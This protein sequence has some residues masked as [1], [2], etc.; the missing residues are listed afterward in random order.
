[1][2]QP[3]PDDATLAAVMNP[4]KLMPLLAGQLALAVMAREDGEHET[5]DRLLR[6]LQQI[7]AGSIRAM[8]GTVES[9]R[10]IFTSLGDQ[11]GLSEANR[12][13]WVAMMLGPEEYPFPPLSPDQTFR[14]LNGQA[15]W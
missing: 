2:T 15:L 14:L 3:R 11:M 1:M 12:E 6:C 8:D 7:A 13:R 4:V 10:R 5:A 9:K